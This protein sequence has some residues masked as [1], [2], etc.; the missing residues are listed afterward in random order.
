[1]QRILKQIEVQQLHPIQYRHRKATN[2][3]FP[4]PDQ[5]W[6]LCLRKRQSPPRFLIKPRKVH[7][8][9]ETHSTEMPSLGFA[10]SGTKNI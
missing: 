9:R 1:M 8:I 5:P 3:N 4:R 6:T 2:R 7:Q 10:F